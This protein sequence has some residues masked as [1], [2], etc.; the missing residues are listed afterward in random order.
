LY[1]E[2]VGYNKAF[3]SVKRPAVLKA[4][5]KQGIHQKYIKTFEKVYCKSTAK[6]KTERTGPS[7]KFGRGA[8]QG[9]PISPKLFTCV[10]EY[11]FRKLD[12]EK[13]E[14]NS[15]TFGLMTI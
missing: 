11:V 3:D 12:W 9:D 7:F 8:R 13:M 6:V 1:L 4:M 2:F 15:P 5:N 10:L 14:K